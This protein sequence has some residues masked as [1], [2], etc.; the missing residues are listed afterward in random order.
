MEDE[1]HNWGKVEVELH[2]PLV[3]V[4]LN[5][6]SI[7]N[8]IFFGSSHR[9]L[10]VLEALYRTPSYRIAKVV[11]QPDRSVG[12]RQTLTPTATSQFAQNHNLKLSRPAQLDDKAI[13]HLT[14]PNLHLIIVSD[15]AL[16]LP[17]KLLE[18]PQFGALNIHP[19]LLP[20]YRGPSPVQWSILRGEKKTGVSIIRMSEEFD[21]GAIIAQKEIL[22]LPQDTQETLYQRCFQEGAKLL[23]KIIPH[24]IRFCQN[25]H[26]SSDQS[27]LPLFLPP[28][29]QSPNSPTPYASRLTKE[30]G[31]IDWNKPAFEI[32]RMI[33]AFDPW[34]GTY[35]TLVELA[36]QFSKEKGKKKVK[37]LK[38]HLDHQGQLQIDKLQIEGKKPLSWEEF[39]RGYLE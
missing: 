11:S 24:W 37:I 4:I 36:P 29:L 1:L 15:Y 38:A 7:I 6:P 9:S 13:S 10:P 39:E 20:A 16:K 31:H 30:Y 22:I 32:E 35:T 33:R 5:M 3:R 17:P 26:P 34:P 28:K 12:R 27:R 18:L 23:L 21:Q 14:L 2:P 8:L 19:S 25:H